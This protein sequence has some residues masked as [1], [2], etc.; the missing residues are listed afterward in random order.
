MPRPKVYDDDLRRRLVSRAALMMA[1]NGPSGLA[2][3]Q[4]AA[5]EDTSTTAIYS[6][7]DDRAGLIREVGRTAAVS[8]VAAQRAVPETDDPFADLLSLGRAYRGWALAHPALY[9]VLMAPAAPG[10]HHFDAAI[11]D[12]EA[13][14]PLR[15]IIL[16]LI[17]ARVFPQLDPNMLLGIIWASVHGFVALE[18]SGFFA[19]TPQDQ[20]DLMY[21]AQL[22]SIRRG[23]SI[24]A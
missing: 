24:T 12:S 5:A 19:P 16:R 23:W 22:E 10:M 20:L 6:M 17:E 4:L 13:A 15:V 7:F 14:D 11:P 21:E 3:R 1:E 8:F 18:L 2:L 9:L